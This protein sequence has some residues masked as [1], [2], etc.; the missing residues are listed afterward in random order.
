MDAGIILRMRIALPKVTCPV[1]GSIDKLVRFLKC[2]ANCER[3][4]LVCLLL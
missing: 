2:I 4:A 1:K 3:S